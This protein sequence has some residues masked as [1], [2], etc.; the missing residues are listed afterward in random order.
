MTQ[1]TI[2]FRGKRID[3][4]EW[5]EASLPYNSRKSGRI[6][7]NQPTQSNG[8]DPCHSRAVHRIDQKN[9]IYDDFEAD[10]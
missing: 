8:V 5:V 7:T 2:L 4:G 10:W 1:R 6:A 3:K 9:G